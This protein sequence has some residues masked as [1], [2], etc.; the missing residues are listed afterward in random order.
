MKFSP[1]FCRFKKTRHHRTNIEKISFA[2]VIM[3]WNINLRKGKKKSCSWKCF[4][5]SLIDRES[6]S[7]CWWHKNSE[8]T[9]KHNSC[10]L[11]KWETS[12]WI[13]SLELDANTK[14]FLFDVQHSR[15]SFKSW[16]KIWAVLKFKMFFKQET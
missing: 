11:S 15:K 12:V 8:S 6:F 2:A 1:L 9:I 5:Y 14:I 10:M 16:F 13:W 3:R 4:N 7:S